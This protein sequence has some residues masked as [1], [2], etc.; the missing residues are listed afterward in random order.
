M[1]ALIDEM[2]KAGVLHATGALE[3]T[4]KGARVRYQGRR[5][6]VIDGPFTESKELVAGYAILE[7]PSLAAAIE[8]TERFGEIVKVNEI[9]IRQMQEW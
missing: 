9:E 8:W 5:R 6:T 7:L 1:G 2:T 3:G 4:K